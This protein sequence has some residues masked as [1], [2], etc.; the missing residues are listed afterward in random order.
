M[1]EGKIAIENKVT[2]LYA[3]GVIRM[4]PVRVAAEELMMLTCWY[5]LL[6]PSNMM[7]FGLMMIMKW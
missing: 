3:T 6:V 5:Y 1:K 2:R 7:S 4:M